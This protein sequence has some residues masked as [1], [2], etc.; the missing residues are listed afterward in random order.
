MTNETQVSGVAAVEA[1]LADAQRFENETRKDTRY[2]DEYKA[3][4]ISM[5]WDMAKQEAKALAERLVSDAAQVVETA[6]AQFNTLAAEHANSIPTDRL[7][8]SHVESQ[9]IAQTAGSYAEI[10][11]KVTQAIARKDVARLQ[12]LRDIALPLLVK[13]ASDNP[14]APLHND[15]GSLMN[16]GRTIDSALADMEPE[17]LKDARRNWQAA[18]QAHYDTVDKLRT[19]NDRARYRTGGLGP[20]GRNEMFVADYS[21]VR[22]KYNQSAQPWPN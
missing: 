12:S 2:T 10:E 15:R 21:N 14:L 6:T 11:A 18:Q 19:I 4:A 17:P 16:L 1:I 8:V 13:R 5:A 22:I 3:K 20:L 7:A 9:T